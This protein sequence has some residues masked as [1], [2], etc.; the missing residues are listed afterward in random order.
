MKNKKVLVIGLDC[1]APDLVF[2]RWKDSLPN[3]GKMIDE[4]TYG[5]LESTVPPITVPAWSSM[6]SGK[7][8]GQL[9]V[10][11]FRNRK[12][13]TYDGLSF[14]TSTSIK[15]D[16]VWDILSRSGK[17]SIVVGVPQTYPP[18]P[19]NGNMV[20]CFLTPSTD[21]QYTYPRELKEEIEENTGDYIIDVHDFRSENL[22][23]TLG[24]IY[25]MTKNHFN[26]IRYLMSE[27]K[28]DFCMLVEMGVDRIHHGFWHHFDENHVLYKPDSPYADAIRKYYIYVDEEIGETLSLVDDNTTVIVVSDHGAKK[29]DGGICINEWLI[30]EGYLKLLEYPESLTPFSKLK[31]DWKNT[32]V[33][34]EGGYYGR[35]FLNV[36]DREPMGSIKPRKYEKVRD[37][38]IKK[39]TALTDESGK[40][41]GTKVFKPEQI[42][43]ECNGVP[44][45]LIV[46]FG[47]LDWRSIGSVGTGSIYTY[48]N[49]T[50]PDGANH[51]QHGIFIMKSPDGNSGEVEGLHITDV[52]PTVLDILDESIPLNIRGK[53]IK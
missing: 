6:M 17:S 36:K 51:A 27:K 37:E 48:E 33:W 10:Y 18:K 49:D 40:N 26:L 16:R 19:L 13:H 41:I 1:A 9:G 52:A 5:K 46:H 45:D 30:K 20:S 15:V 43:A 28:W 38:L 29:M 31:V 50:G 39:L 11:G 44:P 12:D 42:Y 34:G 22:D 3:I 2:N 14:A 21:V 7:D 32:K 53:V 47:N 23:G 25:K 4:G 35:I 8:P 24:N